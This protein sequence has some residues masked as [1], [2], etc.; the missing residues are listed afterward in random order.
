MTFDAVPHAGHTQSWNVAPALYER[1]LTDSFD[2]SSR[3][4]PGRPGRR[5]D[6]EAVLDLW[7]PLAASM[8]AAPTGETDV[9]RM[10]AEFPGALLVAE[11]ERSHGGR[12]GDR[13]LGRLAR[14]HYRLAVDGSAADRGSAAP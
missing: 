4:D 13:R 8:R 6:V 2:R 11:D 14:Q 5:D 1:R 3:D 7:K 10:L 12:R 9:E